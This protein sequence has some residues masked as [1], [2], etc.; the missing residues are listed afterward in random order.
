[1]TYAVDNRVVPP[2][3]IEQETGQMVANSKV[4]RIY[5][6]EIGMPSVESSAPR[7]TGEC[8]GEIEVDGIRHDR[9]PVIS[10]PVS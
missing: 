4:I 2:T 6:P 5:F 8:L 7:P 1:M 3:V 10:N 9:V